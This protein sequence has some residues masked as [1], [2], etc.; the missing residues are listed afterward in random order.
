MAEASICHFQA[1]HQDV[2][3]PDIITFHL[4]FLSRSSTG[5][6]EILIQEL[7]LGQQFSIVRIQLLQKHAGKSRLRIEATCTMGNIS[8]E[9]LSGGISLPTRPII[10]TL[11]AIPRLCDCE[12]WNRDPRLV[13]RRQGAMKIKVYMPRGTQS[14]MAHPTLGPSVREHWVKWEDHAAQEGFC[15]ASL[16]YLADAFRPLPESY[17]LKGNWFPT[18]SY[19]LDIKKVPPTARGWDWLF[20]R[21]EMN[22]VKNGRF[23]MSVMIFD[24]E[25]ELVAMGNHTALILAATR[26]LT[27]GVKA[28]QS[29]I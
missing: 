3:Q 10:S 8:K 2:N 25:G 28:V 1:E 24:E 27:K 6:A 21:I 29:K 15:V 16:L 9:A 17:G 23:D 7:K 20:L 4:N 11:R 12:L 22:V 14:L 26:G 18:L 13:P 5:P 19:G